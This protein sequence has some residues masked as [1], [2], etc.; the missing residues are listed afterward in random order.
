LNEEDL[1]K[2]I[3]FVEENYIDVKIFDVNQVRDIFGLIDT[4]IEKYLAP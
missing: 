1:E 2:A 3:N 4:L